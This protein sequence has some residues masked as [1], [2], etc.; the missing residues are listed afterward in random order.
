MLT[1]AG[2]TFSEAEIILSDVSTYDCPSTIAGL[3]SDPGLPLPLPNARNSAATKTE[4]VSEEIKAILSVDPGRNLPGL[5][6][7]RG[8]Y[9]ERRL[10]RV[11]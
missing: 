10:T 5:E 8:Q 4:L 3:A 6:P 7:E 9:R 11:E 2:L 1:T